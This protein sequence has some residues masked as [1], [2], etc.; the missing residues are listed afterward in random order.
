MPNMFFYCVVCLYTVGMN[1]GKTGGVFRIENERNDKCIHECTH[2]YTITQ[3]G[4]VVQIALATDFQKSRMT[5][6]VFICAI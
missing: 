1:G 2:T 5:N 6:Y 3:Y 4:F